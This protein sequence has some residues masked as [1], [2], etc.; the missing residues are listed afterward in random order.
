M[1]IQNDIEKLDRKLH[2]LATRIVRKASM[3]A[4]RR[5]SAIVVV[6]MKDRVPPATTPG[7]SVVSTKKTI[8]YKVLPKKSPDVV[9]SRIGVIAGGS[10][11]KRPH[12]HLIALGTVIRTRREFNHLRLCLSL[13]P[14]VWRAKATVTCLP[15]RYLVRGF[16]HRHAV[17]LPLSPAGFAMAVFNVDMHR[18]GLPVLD[19]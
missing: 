19:V 9:T 14:A 6:A 15:G 1:T 7:H 4:I 12:A 16:D 17:L 11:D 13:E 3:A 5:A 10:R 8:R 18:S 2:D